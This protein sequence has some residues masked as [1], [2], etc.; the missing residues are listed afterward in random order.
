MLLDAKIWRVSKSRNLGNLKRKLFF[1]LSPCHQNKI[2]TLFQKTNIRFYTK[3]ELSAL[4]VSVSAQTTELSDSHPREER[5]GIFICIFST[6]FNKLCDSFD[7]ITTSAVFQDTLCFLFSFLPP[8]GCRRNC[9][10]VFGGCVGKSVIQCRTLSAF[11]ST[12]PTAPPCCQAED[13]CMANDG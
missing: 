1:F 5:M 13:D 4:A 3:P 12:G 2:K 8:S 6:W 10:C 9:M 11:F 7:L